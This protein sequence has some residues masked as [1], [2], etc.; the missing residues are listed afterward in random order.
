MFFAVGYEEANHYRSLRPQ[1]LAVPHARGADPIG[2]WGI[3]AV[4]PGQVRVSGWA[5]DPETSMPIVVRVVVDG[6][7]RATLL[8]ND[9]RADVGAQYVGNGPFHGATLTLGVRRGW[10]R[11]CVRALGVGAG[12]SVKTLACKRVRVR[13]TTPPTTT[14]T[15]TSTTTTVVESTST[16]TTSTST[17]STSTTTT[18]NP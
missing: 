13:G 17:T 8:A 2:R 4:Y 12:R 11:V 14:T 1:A 5:L 3:T 7:E 16:S 9:E 15:T 10:H 6:N 18:S